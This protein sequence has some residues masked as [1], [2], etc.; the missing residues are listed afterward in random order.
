MLKPKAMFRSKPNEFSVQSK[1]CPC[2]RS[3]Y[4]QKSSVRTL[5]TTAGRLRVGKNASTRSGP[6]LLKR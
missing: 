3:C 2:G 6:A 4:K 1:P 5:A